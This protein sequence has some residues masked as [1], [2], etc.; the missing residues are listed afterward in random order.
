MKTVKR[1]E[2]FMELDMVGI[3]DVWWIDFDGALESSPRF[4]PADK[5]D[6]Y[7]EWLDSPE[8]DVVG[9]LLLNA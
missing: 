1:S 9:Q 5:E 8:W 7:S 4:F 2:V 6:V 3:T